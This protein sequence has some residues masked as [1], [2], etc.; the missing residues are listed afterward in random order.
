VILGCLPA[1]PATDLQ[2]I[3]NGAP[4]PAKA[5]TWSQQPGL[6]PITY[7]AKLPEKLTPGDT[8]KVHQS[9]PPQRDPDSPAQVVAALPKPP[10]TI[11]AVQEG[12]TTVTGSAPGLDKVRVQLVDGA[13]VKAQAPDATVDSTTNLFTATFTSPL[14]ADQQLK[15]FGLAKS[16]TPSDTATLVEVQP[17]G[18]DWGQVRGYFTA[19]VILSSNNS[20]FNLTNA[21]AFL[22]FALD[23][24]WLQPSRAYNSINGGF[25]ERFRLHTYFDAR[26]TAIASGTSGSS[27]SSTT[28]TLSSGSTSTT[29][30]STTS[31]SSTA[32]PSPNPT[33]LLSNGQ[34]AALQVGAYFPIVFHQ[35]DHRDRSYSMYLAPLAK[36]GFYTLTSAGTATNQTAENATRSTGSFFPFFGYGLRLGHYREYQTWDGRTDPSRAP[37]QLSYLDFT[38][39]KW[40]NFEYLAPFNY[41]LTTTPTCTLPATD[42]TTAACDERQRLWRY[43]FE[44]ILVI[45]NTPLIL[46]ISANISAQKPRSAT[47]G[48]IFFYP[49]DDLRFLFGVR[50]DASKFT[51][52]L[53]K[54]GGQ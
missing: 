12:A 5:V 27:S 51:G 3:I 14:Q 21:N 53:N 8:I 18:L 28:P 30:S 7:S 31:T 36:V 44:G 46:G 33:S 37:E 22:G 49:P 43:A 6:T 16:G 13:D 11:F 29:G 54:L 23:K 35:W 42:P 24:S 50:F 48:A 15:I 25:R 10:T 47:P 38:I 45:P 1:Q 40:A 17:Y 26:L 39:G 19:G 34:A 52:I 2:V 32:N 4:L 9:N 41:T 20:Q